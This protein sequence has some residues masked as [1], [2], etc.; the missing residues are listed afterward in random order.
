MLTI[1]LL[2]KTHIE[3]KKRSLSAI[4]PKPRIHTI[5]FKNWIIT[6]SCGSQY[7]NSGSVQWACKYHLP[8]V[9]IVIDPPIIDDSEVKRKNLENWQ[10]SFEKFMSRY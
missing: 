10:K 3:V 8:R 6:D 9:G 5:D 2:D 4:D 1:T 7:M